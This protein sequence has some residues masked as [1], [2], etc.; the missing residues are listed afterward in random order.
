MRE[1]C[2]R[3]VL[4]AV[5]AVGSEGALLYAADEARRRRCDI[6]LVHVAPLL[7]D[8]GLDRD[9]SA[10]AVSNRLHRSTGALLGDA[11]ALLE[12]ELRDDTLS[13]STE[14]CWGAVVPSLVAESVRGCLLIIQRRCAGT[15][16]DDPA[17]CATEAIAAR[18]RAPVVAVPVGWSTPSVRNPTV[19]VGV[20]DRQA[21]AEVVRIALEHAARADGRLRLVRA[22]NPPPTVRGRSTADADLPRLSAELAT[23]F[24]ETLAAHP[25]VPVEMTISQ[26]D[27]AESL[28]ELAPESSLLVVGRRQPRLPLPWTL[29]PVAR[30]V[31]HGSEAPVLVVEADGEESP[32]SL[33]LQ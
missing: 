15:R 12:R 21:S 27:P 13:V 10:R 31:L 20:L 7:M 25:E 19:T 5:D 26:Q 1:S 8:G 23:E 11:R 3:K 4:V 29:G 6:H 22:Y 33:R 24:A 18:A 32:S 28:L 17:D 14:V 16:H 30:A 2:P 9:P